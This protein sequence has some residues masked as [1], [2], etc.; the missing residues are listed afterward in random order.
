MIDVGIHGVN[1]IKTEDR[2]RLVLDSGQPFETRALSIRGIAEDG[3]V[4]H[5][6]KITLFSFGTATDLLTDT[7]K[8]AHAVIEQLLE[9]LHEAKQCVGCGSH[10]KSCS[11]CPV[12]DVIEKAIAEGEEAL[13]DKENDNA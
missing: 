8:Q 7:E 9:A 11:Q 3:S 2:R 13:P 1:V 10:P 5:L 4:E 6:A 12:Y